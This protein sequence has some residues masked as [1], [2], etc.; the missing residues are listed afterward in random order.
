LDII[1]RSNH[2]RVEVSHSVLCFSDVYSRP[3]VGSTVDLSLRET[4]I[5][6]PFRFR[7]GETLEISIAIPPKVIKCKGEVVHV[8][9]SKGEI[10]KAG[11]R[12]EDLSKEDELYLGQYIS[13][14]RE[15]GKGDLE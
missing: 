6:T 1:E 13:H 15:S 9:G 11:V 3:V 14:L 12:F 2:P 10:P 5:R 7:A 4:T 8:L